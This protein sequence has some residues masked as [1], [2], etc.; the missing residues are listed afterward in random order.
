MSKKI[1]DKYRKLTETEHVLQRPSM[2]IGSTSINISNKYIIENNECILKEIKQIPGFIKL[3]DEIIMNSV[4]ESKRNPKLDRI[5]VDIDLKTNKISVKDNGGI[6]VQKH[7]EYNEWIPEMLF[8]TLKAGSNFDD[9]ESREVGGLN[10][11][12]SVLVNIFSTEFKIS[13]CDGKNTFVQTFYNNMEKRD[14]PTIKKSKNNHTEISYTPD[15]KRFNLSEI[16]NDHYKIVEKRVYD[17][18]GCNHKIKFYFNGSL[19]KINNFNDYI[20]LYTNDFYSEKSNDS[21]WEIGIGLS[22]DGFKQISYVN[23]VETYDGGTHVDLVSNQIV[24]ELR[25]YISKKYKFDMKP[26]DIKSHLFIFINST[27]I[28]PS[29]SSQ[30]KEKL[31][32]EVKDFGSKYT[33]S[34]KLIKWLYKSDI[35]ESIGDW[36][37]RK[38]IADDNKLTRELNKSLSKKKIEKL[39]DAKSSDRS[40]CSLFIFE[41]DSASN[42][43]RD[44]RDVQTQGI[45]SLRGKV[46]NVSE[47]NTRKLI[48]NKEV[49]GLM[50]AIGLK[51]GD[52][53]FSKLR[54]K[55]IIITCDADYDGSSISA[56]LIN[57]FYKYW[58]DLFKLGYIYKSETPIVISTNKKTKNKLKF[59]KQRDFNEWIENC[60]DIEKWD[61]K[62]KKGLASLT[63]DEY[64]EIIENPILTQISIDDK[65]KHSLN[66]WFG[67][68]TKYRKNEL[69]K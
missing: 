2:Y 4:D 68:D 19:V 21:R 69:L 63:E 64:K 61:I 34:D 35:L 5:D 25:S 16:D 26:S 52:N 10:G 20:K 48:E 31:I 17:L 51:L 44:H 54:Y 49:F 43:A 58:S 7:K 40:K 14:K 9:T 12:G 46:L 22:N 23:S 13:T 39:I 29:F 27:I 36:I 18:A 30:S 62:Y 8:S 15:L 66:V 32:T 59:Y 56:L 37:D 1:E 28:N 55:K 67:K 60:K 24:N 57:F 53:D 47:V 11:V 41:G 45:Y 50:S 33:I 65:S 3:F 38:K 6:P 42:N